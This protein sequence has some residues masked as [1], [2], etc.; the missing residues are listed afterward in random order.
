VTAQLG[1]AALLAAALAAAPAVADDRPPGRR[2]VL[3]GG[4]V[5]EVAAARVEGGLVYVTLLDGV[6]H[7]Y[8]TEDVDLA[9]S[10]LAAAVGKA[11]PPPPVAPPSLAAA[12]GRPEGV[13]SRFTLTDADVAHVQRSQAEPQ[14]GAGDATTGG[15]D[16][17]P[18]SAALSVTGL[19]REVRGDV[20][21]LSGAVQNQGAKPVSSV[22]LVALAVDEQGNVQGSGST[23]V[24]RTL[25]PQASV[26]F[27]MS[28]KVK[29]PVANVKVR[30]S[31]TVA[32]L[33]F[34]QER[35]RPD[36]GSSEPDE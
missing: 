7:A 23:T 25:T 11:P 5:L 20:L 32:D 13:T 22:N 10:G 14:S 12:P 2:L 27:S 31:A 9:A 24:G 21:T 16:E 18:S 35:R 26:G 34:P 33:S 28:F 29:G 17:T 19:R 36:R 8:L 3:D 15:V 30:A 1:L 4:D 6:M